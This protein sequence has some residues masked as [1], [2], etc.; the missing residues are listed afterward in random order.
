[1][2]QKEVNAMST[3]SERPIGLQAGQFSMAAMLSVVFACAVYFG[4]LRITGDY[5]S[6][7][8]NGGRFGVRENQWLPPLSIFVSWFVLMA[9]YNYWQLPSA[10]RVHYAGPVIFTPLALLLCLAAG[11]RDSIF[12]Q[13]FVY[14]FFVSVLFG[15]PIV[16]IML[17]A[18]FVRRS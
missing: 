11:A 5:L 17:F 10:M 16:A 14:G 6:L 4:F 12:P 13:L 8:G 2:K 7:L 1:L 18:R 9:I 15:F 3:G